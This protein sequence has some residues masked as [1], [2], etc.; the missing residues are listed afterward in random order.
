MPSFRIP[1]SPAMAAPFGLNLAAP[2][3]HFRSYHFSTDDGRGG[4]V[5]L[6]YVYESTAYPSRHG[7]FVAHIDSAGNLRQKPLVRLTRALDEHKL[8]PEMIR[9]F[10]T[11][12]VIGASI[13]VSVVKV[14][15]GLFLGD[16]TQDEFRFLPNCGSRISVFSPGIVYGTLHHNH[17]CRH[18]PASFDDAVCRYEKFNPAAVDV[19]SLGSVRLVAHLQP[20]H[21]IDFP[22][23]LPAPP[24]SPFVTN[25]YDGVYT[26]SVEALPD[27]R[28]LV[29]IW[30]TAQNSL[31]DYYF[32]IFTPEGRV[33]AVIRGTEKRAPIAYS[34]KRGQLVAIGETTS[35]LID[36]AGNIVENVAHPPRTKSVFRRF[37]F[38]GIGPT[39]GARFVSSPLVDDQTNTV[40]VVA[41]PVSPTAPSISPACTGRW[42]TTING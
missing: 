27:G 40:L 4:A 34:R 38:A 22:G 36:L 6:S 33:D 16:W 37:P 19:P 3:N 39:S 14:R 23:L 26:N 11:R 28:V 25:P 13:G 15:C 24:G 20:L 12:A 30:N 32:V 29:S 9:T 31:E 8:S 2:E 42:S 18:H 21:N 7:C 41:E 5:I 17:E 1:I 10:G 35:Q